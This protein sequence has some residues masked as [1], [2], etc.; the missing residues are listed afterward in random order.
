MVCFCS[1][2]DQIYMWMNQEN[3]WT[4]LYTTKMQFADYDRQ[5]NLTMTYMWTKQQRKSRFT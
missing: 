2:Q 5:F 1:F 4:S 3:P